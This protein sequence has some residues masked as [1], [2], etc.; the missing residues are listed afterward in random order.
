[1]ESDCLGLTLA[2]CDLLIM[3]CKRRLNPHN[4]ARQALQSLALQALEDNGG[5][6]EIAVGSTFC[7][8][9]TGNGGA[10]VWGGLPGAGSLQHS[11]T[12]HERKLLPR[13]MQ[14]AEVM[15]MPPIKHIA[16]GHGHA[17][18]SDGERVWALGQ[19]VPA[20]IQTPS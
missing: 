11:G 20:P 10:V 16:A 8:C 3:S 5:A 7:L 9:R 13:G 1:M 15:G 2:T 19:C 14:V 12:S 17:L 4:K 18:L 6:V